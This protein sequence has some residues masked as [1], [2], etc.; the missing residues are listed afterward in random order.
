[1]F[2]ITGKILDIESTLAGYMTE[3]AVTIVRSSV[4]YRWQRM[5]E[6]KRQ[7]V[8]NCKSAALLKTVK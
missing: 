8:D 2:D 7:R 6:R 1:M 4:E 3:T 5:Q